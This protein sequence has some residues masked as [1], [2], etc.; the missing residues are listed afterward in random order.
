MSEL[1]K[2]LWRAIYENTL[3]YRMIEYAFTRF[4]IWRLF[5]Y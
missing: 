1:Q 4:L 2:Y 3:R 5:H